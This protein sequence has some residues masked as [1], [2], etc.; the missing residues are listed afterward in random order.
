[1]LRIRAAVAGHHSD[2]QEVEGHRIAVVAGGVRSVAAEVVGV[3]E[4]RIGRQE[5]TVLQEGDSG[6]AEA[7]EVGDIARR[8]EEDNI[9]VVVVG[10]DIALGEDIVPAEGIALEAD[11]ALA[12]EEGTVLAADIAGAAGEVAGR[13]GRLR[14][15]AGCSKTSE[16]CGSS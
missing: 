2:R 5:G 7:V 1:M 4:V 11:I 14:R 6:L 10:V 9:L 3:L 15:A 8:L 12:A 16:G 13:I